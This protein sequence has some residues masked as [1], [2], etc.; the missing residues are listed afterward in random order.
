MILTLKLT[1]G[2]LLHIPVSEISHIIEERG[3]KEGHSFNLC[4]KGD[5]EAYYV[6]KDIFRE[7]RAESDFSYVLGLLK[8]HHQL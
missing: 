6:I 4:V 8:A 3:E 5:P 2:N 7:G 1:N